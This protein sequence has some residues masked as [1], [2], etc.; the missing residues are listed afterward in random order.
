MKTS[1]CAFT[2]IELLIVVAIIAILAAIAI[3]NF[4]EAQIR[5]KIGR[6]KADMRSIAAALEGYRV[7]QNGYPQGS[8]HWHSQALLT[9]PVAYISI[10]P[11]DPFG[12][13][14]PGSP[15]FYLYENHYIYTSL[16]SFDPRTDWD[17]YRRTFFE[18]K[19]R[20]CAWALLSRGPDRRYEENGGGPGTPLRESAY[21]STNGTTSRG[22]IERFGP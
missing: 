21:D 5:S 1:D 6:A 3:P 19:R 13:D 10:M 16:F 12:S 17:Q 14:P 22:D 4:L 7:E 18:A 15:Y 8:G 20:G 11:K 9:T 2:L